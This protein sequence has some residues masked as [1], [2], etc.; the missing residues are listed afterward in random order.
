MSE[1]SFVRKFIFLAVTL[2]DDIDFPH[3]SNNLFS[4]PR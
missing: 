1:S 2:E 4:M 3:E